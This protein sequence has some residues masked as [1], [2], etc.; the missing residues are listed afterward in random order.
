MSPV[1]NLLIKCLVTKLRTN[2][3]V[4]KVLLYVN[5]TEKWTG[6]KNTGLN[7]P[8]EDQIYVEVGNY[9]SC[10]ILCFNVG[11]LI[12]GLTCARNLKK[13][14]MLQTPLLVYFNF[15]PNIFS[16]ILSCQ[17]RGAA[18]LRVRLIRWCLR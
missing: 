18:Y 6:M 1:L 13:Q 16:K 2:Q 17:T 12:H 4:N 9:R 7:M 11:E 14:C 15:F 8:E 10:S 5:S 3:N